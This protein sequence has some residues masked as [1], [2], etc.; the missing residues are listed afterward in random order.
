M[1]VTFGLL[2]LS[3]IATDVPLLPK[4]FAVVE[5]PLNNS[6]QT[7]SKNDAIVNR[8]DLPV[9]YQITRA[10]IMGT[11]A[12]TET[13]NYRE[14]W[15]LEIRAG[16]IAFIQ[17]PSGSVPI[18]LSNIVKDSNRPSA[19]II[20]EKDFA[21]LVGVKIPITNEEEAELEEQKARMITLQLDRSGTGTSYNVNISEEERLVVHLEVGSSTN[22][23]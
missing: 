17:S 18:Y 19:L 9:H 2:N 7:K 1:F 22:T 5:A 4:A 14:T 15:T 21:T 6:S 16:G 8:L 12:T 10:R 3:S 11:E 20:L 13:E 23:F